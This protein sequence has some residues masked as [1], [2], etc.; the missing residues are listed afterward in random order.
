MED[1]VQSSWTHYLNN[2]VNNKRLDLN[3]LYAGILSS[4]QAFYLIIDFENNG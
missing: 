4:Q 3:R 2:M 1:N